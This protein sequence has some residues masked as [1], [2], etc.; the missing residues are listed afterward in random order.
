VHLTLSDTALPNS[1]L[2]C[3]YVGF[4]NESG[5]SIQSITIRCKSTNPNALA[6]IR[7]GNKVELVAAA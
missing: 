6:L 4:L 5:A 3:R 2:L 7:I 1:L